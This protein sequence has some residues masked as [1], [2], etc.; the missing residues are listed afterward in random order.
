MINRFYIGRDRPNGGALY[1]YFVRPKW[2]I[3]EQMF[4]VQY[5]NKL[6]TIELPKTMFPHIN[7]GKLYKFETKNPT[8]EFIE[9]G[10]INKTMKFARN[11]HRPIVLNK[12][13][14]V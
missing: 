7:I 9:Q 6:P 8:G 3:V 2:N 1:L 5:G 11:K 10:V 12:G 14:K 4:Y 13:L